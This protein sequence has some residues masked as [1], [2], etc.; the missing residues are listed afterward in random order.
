MEWKVFCMYLANIEIIQNMSSLDLEVSVESI[1]GK[2]PLRSPQAVAPD[3]IPHGVSVQPR[4]TNPAFI[5]GR[6]KGDHISQAISIAMARAIAYISVRWW[7][8]P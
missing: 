4:E 3:E 2:V 6:L 7:L 8:E 1:L 5:I